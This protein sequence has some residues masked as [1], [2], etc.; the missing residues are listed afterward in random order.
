MPVSIAMPSGVE[1]A[2]TQ[3]DPSGVACVT[4]LRDVISVALFTSR[5]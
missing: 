3:S 5:S 1:E 4:N 2:A